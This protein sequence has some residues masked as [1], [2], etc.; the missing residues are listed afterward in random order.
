MLLFYISQKQIFLQQTSHSPKVSNHPTPGSFRPKHSKDAFL[1]DHRRR[2]HRRRFLRP[3]RTGSRS[4]PSCSSLP[5]NLRQSGHTTTRRPS[6]HQRLQ[7]RFLRRYCA[8]VYFSYGHKM[9]A[10]HQ[11][12]VYNCQCQVSFPFIFTLACRP[13]SAHGIAVSIGLIGVETADA[14]LRF[15]AAMTAE[16]IHTGSRTQAVMRY[17]LPPS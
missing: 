7:Q 11:R 6:C 17:C 4:C 8:D 9:P 12:S 1:Q 16:E 15:G 10:R 5:R 2:H 13:F 3:R 14:P